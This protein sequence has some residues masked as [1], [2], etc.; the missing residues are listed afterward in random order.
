MAKCVYCKCEINDDR[1]VDVCDKCG[2]KVWGERCFNAIKQNMT[3]AKE[4]GDLHQ[5]LI[6]IDN[7]KSSKLRL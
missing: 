5:G 7:V 2:M 6:N 1:A 3:N 4:K